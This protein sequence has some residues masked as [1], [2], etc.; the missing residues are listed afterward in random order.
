[1]IFLIFFAFIAGFVTILSP[2]ILPVLPIVLSGSLSGGKKRPIGVVTGF[3]AS[4][5]FFTL[6]LSAIVKATNLSSGSLRTL[7]VGIVFIFGLVLIFPQVQVIFEKITSKFSSISNKNNKND[8][9]FSGI[10]VGLSLGLVWAPCVGP[11]LAS[12]ITLSATSSITLTSVFITLAY[13]LG[14]AI[15]MLFITYSGRRIFEKLPGLLSHTTQIQQMFG[16]IMIFTALAIYMNFDLKFQVYILDKFPGY[17]EGLTSIE[18]NEIVRTQLD[19]LSQSGDSMQKITEKTVTGSLLSKPEIKAPDFMSGGAWI[20]SEPLSLKN[21][22]KGKVVLVDFWTYTCINCIRTLPYVTGWDEKYSGEEFEII[23]VHSPEFDF[24]KD[25]NNVISA[26]KNYNINYPIVQDNNFNI[27]KSYANRYWPAHYLIDK[28]GYIRYTHFGEGKYIETENAIREL[29]NEEPIEANEENSKRTIL[30]PETYLG[31][32]RAGSYSTQNDINIDEVTDYSL[33]KSV[34]DNEI[35]LSGSWIVGPEAIIAQ[36]NGSKLQVNFV[37]SQVFLVM[38]PPKNKTGNVRVLLNGKPIP[39]SYLTS[40]M[41]ESGVIQI[42]EARKYD[43][44]DLKLDYGRNILDLEFS[45]GVQ[46]FAFTFG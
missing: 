17:G 38:K 39:Q 10:I 28:N 20:N 45:E 11:I 21:E 33:I 29:L 18:D 31:Y 44:I 40:D 14:T 5:T 16:V 7:A 36:Q 32:E 4:F 30:T 8:G 25:T 46:A 2:C 6:L 26:T 12:V 24:E 34:R 19:K 23:G 35:G 43:I 22:L 9:F 27:W 13:A 15:P 3:I 37:G 1:M 41:D 42:Q